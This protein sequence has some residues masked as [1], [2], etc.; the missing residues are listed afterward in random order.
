MARPKKQET[1]EKKIIEIETC[2]ARLKKEYDQAL[3]DLK[4]LREQQKLLQSQ[5]LL[6]A[7]DKKGKSFD[8][9]LRLINL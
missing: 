2:V 8:E 3:S 4:N 7:M 5:K 1:I 6:D 9:V